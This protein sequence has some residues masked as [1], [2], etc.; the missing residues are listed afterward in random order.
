MSSLRLLPLALL[1][2]FTGP[3]GAWEFVSETSALSPH[4]IATIGAYSDDVG[5]ALR[6]ENGKQVGLLTTPER[7]STASLATLA[8][9]DVAS[10]WKADDADVASADAKPF[11]HGGHVAL[12]F[13]APDTLLDQLASAR[14]R[15]VVGASVGGMVAHETTFD[16]QGA[17]NA[18]LQ[19]RNACDAR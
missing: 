14:Q 18:V 4:P 12:V 3:A 15:F 7:A 6:C 11:E 2:A 1:T 5:F 17:A 16:V 13:F 10:L 9:V 8:K 19:F